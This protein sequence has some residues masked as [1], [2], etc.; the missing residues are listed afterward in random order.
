VGKSKARFARR[1]H[2][3]VGAGYPPHP[4]EHHLLSLRAELVRFALRYFFKSR[5]GPAPTIEGWRRRMGGLGRLV[6]RPPQGTL[7]ER[8]DLDGIGAVSIATPESRSDRHI[9]YLHGGGHV[10][11]SPKLYRDFSWRIAAAAR[12]R[13]LMTYHRLAPEHPYPAAI[14]DA[15]N[16]YRALVAGG[17]DPRAMALMGESAGGGLVLGVLLKLRDEGNPLPAAAVTISPW[18]DLALS[19]SSY[20]QND[21]ADPMLSRTDAARMASYYLG[22]TDPRTPYASP[23]YGDPSGLPPTLIQVGSDEILLDDSVQMAKRM[24][25]AGCEVELEVWPRMPHAWHVWARV[26]PEARAAIARIGVF[27]QDKWRVANGE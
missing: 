24:R 17:A 18:T 11:G 14:E 15:A 27:V 21:G 4:Q 23:I 5:S 6:P 9:L 16:A 25:A 12:A 8:L 20:R 26:M 13:V 3:H 10:S 7:V 19:G 22:A 2:H 1:A